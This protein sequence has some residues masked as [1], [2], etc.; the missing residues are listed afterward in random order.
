[1][2]LGEIGE[3]LCIPPN[4]SPAP[5]ASRPSHT[6]LAPTYAR[7]GL[8][9]VYFLVSVGPC[10]HVHS[11]G[12]TGAAGPLESALS[13]ILQVRCSLGRLSSK[14]KDLMPMHNNYCDRVPL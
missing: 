11:W 1:M 5:R 2:T 12:V 13:H 8:A 10:W 14:P 9:W 7:G 3:C 6:T 4:G